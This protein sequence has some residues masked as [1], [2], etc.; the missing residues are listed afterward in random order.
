M[1]VNEGLLWRILDHAVIFEVSGR[2]C[3]R[4]LHSRLTQDIASLKHS[5]SAMA[6]A[7]SAQGRVEGLFC[8]LNE[9]P[10]T[11]IGAGARFLILSDGG[12][13]LELLSVLRRFVVADRINFVDLSSELKVLHIAADLKEPLLQ[14]LATIEE[15]LGAGKLR[16]K[17]ERKRL[18]TFGFDLVVSAGELSKVELLLSELLGAQLTSRSYDL[19]RWKAGCA[20][21]PDE[22][23]GEGMVLEYGLRDAV[24]FSK[25]CYVGQEVVERSD[26]VGRVPRCLERLVIDSGE[27]LQ[28]SYEQLKGAV[29][30][31]VAK[32]VLGRVVGVIPDRLDCQEGNGVSGA[33]SGYKLFALL[34]NG[35]YQLS[36]ELIC[37]DA[38]RCRLVR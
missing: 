19:Q 32:E 5:S 20:T 3:I 16:A 36:D 2:D 14:V 26:A 9:A 29:I 6:A 25:G 31:N 34:R 7:L 15:K 10:D 38:I 11:E 27:P 21:F 24:S 37:G 12:D 4:Y 13:P 23:N 17:I 22:I 1:S 28:Q 35:R 8:V 30:T 18:L 33:L